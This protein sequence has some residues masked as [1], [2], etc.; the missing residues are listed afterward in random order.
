MAA[1]L[2]VLC[3]YMVLFLN[4]ESPQNTWFVSNWDPPKTKNQIKWLAFFGF[5][6]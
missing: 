3:Y 6:A 4:G 5:L 1:S 2:L